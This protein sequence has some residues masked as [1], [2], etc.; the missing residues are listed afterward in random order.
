M[1]LGEGEMGLIV[2]NTNR[3]LVSGC[4][5]G[6]CICLD[7]GAEELPTYVPRPDALRE[8]IPEIYKWDL[9][10]LFPDVQAWDKARVSLLEMLPEVEACRGRVAKSARDF[11]HC[12]DLV[13]S[14]A[15]QIDRVA[16]YARLQYAIDRTDAAA[17]FRSDQAD[18]LVIRFNEAKAFL[19]PELLAAD[20]NRLLSYVKKPALA[21]YRHFID[22]IVRRR[23]HILS[24]GEERLLAMAA[25]LAGTAKFILGG[26]EEE[27]RF[28]SVIGPAGQQLTLTRSS[29]PK[30]RSHESREVRED[31]VRKFFSTLGTFG[32]TFTGVLDLT[33]KANTMEA[34]ARGYSS[35]LE[36]SLDRN[37]IPVNLYERLLEVVSSNLPQTLHRYVEMRR[38]MMGLSEVRYHDL[39]VALVSPPFCD[40]P[41][42]HALDLVKEAM[43][44][45]G[46][47]YM[48]VLAEGLDARNRWIDAMPSK[49]K[50]SGAFCTATYRDRPLVFLNYNG[51]VEDVFTLAHEFGHA[52][53]FWFAHR[54]QDYVNAEA[55]IFLAE[56]ASTFH[57]AMLLSYF[58]EHA[59]SREE[60]IFYLNRRLES[61]RTTVFR[62]VM[63]AE[64]EKDIYRVVEEGGAL[65]ADGLAKMYQGLIRKYYGPAF[66]IGE[67]DKWE[68]IYIPHFH[69]NF[70]VFQYAT[71]LMIATGLA[72]SVKAGEKQAVEKYIELL[73]AGGSDYPLEIL[74]RAGVNIEEAMQ[75]TLEL[76]SKTLD[77]LETLQP[78]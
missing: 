44:P 66:A 23:R 55:P 26:L 51:E 38:R 64:F 21:K 2:L 30:L 61:I 16:T 14:L 6:L 68:W 1:G 47:E 34:R 57:E 28:P 22:D 9:S 43:R 74:K 41:F 50:R 15:E 53:H 73:K 46:E 11:A 19:E 39:Y 36:A 58:L 45:L 70:Y 71:G 52:M 67:H 59:R 37:A 40:L 4:A 60:K 72:T 27:V 31:A 7:A 24:P 78:K 49:G 17:K 56:I 12:M 25:E 20:P 62:Q 75:A 65:T 35:A 8:E 3:T 33:V 54:A 32:N 13:L 29:F 48:R 63:F 76:F 5:L 42:G 18:A 69:Y 77:E 10:Y